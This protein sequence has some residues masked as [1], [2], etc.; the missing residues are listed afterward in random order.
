MK[1]SGRGWS[2]IGSASCSGAREIG[3]GIRCSDLLAPLPSIGAEMPE[4]ARVALTRRLVRGIVQELHGDGGQL[5]SLHVEQVLRLATTHSSGQRIDLPGIIA[6]RSFDW[7]WF[8]SVQQQPASGN[9]NRAALRKNVADP[10]EFSHTVELGESGET[11]VIVIPE[12]AR[13]FR[14]K[15]ID[16]PARERDTNLNRVFSIGTCFA[17]RWFSVIGVRVTRFGPRAGAALTS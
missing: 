10:L 8:S 6:E 15:V 3:A 7:L 9:P 16:W 4:E 12:I 17:R 5:T 14:L 11:A 13:R 1:H 2:P